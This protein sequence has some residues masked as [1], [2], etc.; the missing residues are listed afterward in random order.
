MTAMPDTDAEKTCN[1]H[2]PYDWARSAA[3]VK[4]M[5]TFEEQVNLEVALDATIREFQNQMALWQPRDVTLQEQLAQKLCQLVG[6]DPEA[7]HYP[8][9]PSHRDIYWPMWENYCDVAREIIT[10]VGQAALPPV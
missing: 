6:H 1:S 5:E 8:V 4:G 9:H 3:I 2:D 7:K 10:L